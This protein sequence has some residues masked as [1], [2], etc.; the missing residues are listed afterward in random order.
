MIIKGQQ[1]AAEGGEG[2]EELQNIIQAQNQ[3]IER[4]QGEVIYY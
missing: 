1:P 2:S 3:E 4:L